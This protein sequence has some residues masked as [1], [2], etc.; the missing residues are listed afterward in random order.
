M[1]YY[2]KIKMYESPHYAVFS[3]FSVFYDGG[4]NLHL[5]EG[6]EQTGRLSIPKV[7]HE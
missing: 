3:R 1:K 4:V 5:C 7:R 2:N 6:G